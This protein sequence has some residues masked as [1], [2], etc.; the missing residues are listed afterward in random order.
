MESNDTVY[1]LKE[2]DAGTKM[3]ISSI[4]EVIDYVADFKLRD[5]LNKSIEEH[6]KISTELESLLVKHDSSEKDPSVIAKGMSWL[7]TN[8]KLSVNESD[9]TIADLITEGCNMGIKT[10]NKYLNQ[11]K[12]SD[13][14]ST[15]LC[16]KLISIEEDLCK[17]MR[18]YL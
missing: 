9:A 13:N 10:L 6:E 15:N 5:I 7:K 8:F 18:I 14:E 16:K 11:Y 1:L 4:E 3:A 12:N 2:C 17:D